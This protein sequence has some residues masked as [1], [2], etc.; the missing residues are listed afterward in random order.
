MDSDPKSISNSDPNSISNSN[1]SSL[2]GSVPG[3]CRFC[4]RPAVWAFS[5]QDEMRV[6]RNTRACDDCAE[7][8]KRLGEIRGWELQSTLRLVAEGG[9]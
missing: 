8:E 1:S 7:A 5:W 4:F 6:L 3:G 9:S 2:L